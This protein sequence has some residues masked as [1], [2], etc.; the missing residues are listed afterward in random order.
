MNKPADILMKELES[1]P[2]RASVVCSLLAYERHQCREFSEL[3]Q[4]IVKHT[5]NFKKMLN[6]T[7]GFNSSLIIVCL[8]TCLNV[9]TSNREV[10][11]RSPHH[12]FS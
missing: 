9:Q 4:L 10:F 5:T 2:S 12:L 7:E 6:L 11:A 8:L 3:L 1:S